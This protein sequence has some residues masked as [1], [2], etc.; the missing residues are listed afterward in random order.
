MELF[1]TLNLKLP[2]T[3]KEFLFYLCSSPAWRWSDHNFLPSEP[4][5]RRRDEMDKIVC[6]GGPTTR[7]LPAFVVSAK[8]NTKLQQRQNEYAY[9]WMKKEFFNQ[10][11]YV[12]I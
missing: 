12:H 7:G 8:R 5:T 2:A 3:W 1:E 4:W 10:A 6:A 9:E 11:A